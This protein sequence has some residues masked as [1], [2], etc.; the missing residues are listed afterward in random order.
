L[1]GQFKWSSRNTPEGDHRIDG[2]IVLLADTP[3]VDGRLVNA[4][5]KAFASTDYA[6][7]SEHDGA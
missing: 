7:V 6:V 5:I 2:V 1:I 4:L 3:M